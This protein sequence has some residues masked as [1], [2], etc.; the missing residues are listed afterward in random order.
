MFPSSLLAHPPKPLL[1]DEETILLKLDAAAELRIRRVKL[2]L[3]FA[4]TVTWVGNAR[5]AAFC[6][7][8]RPRWV[9]ILI[10]EYEVAA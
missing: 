3:P 6:C 2:V 8:L 5:L 1:V 10:E 4:N 7:G 9:K